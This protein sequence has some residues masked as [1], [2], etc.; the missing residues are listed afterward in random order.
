M[1]KIHFLLLDGDV[2]DTSMGLGDDAAQ[3]VVSFFV[4]LFKLAE[5]K[6]IPIVM[7]R[8][9]LSHDRNHLRTIAALHEKYGFKTKLYYVEKLSIGLI[10]EYDL[11]I[12]Y[13]PDNLPYKESDEAIDVLKEQMHTAGWDYVD[14]AFVHGY[15]RHVLPEGIP[16]EPPCTFRVEQFSFVKRYVATGHVHTPSQRDNQFYNGS[17]DRLGHG[18]EEPKGFMYVIDDGTNAEIHFIENE[19]ATP[20]ITYDLSHLSDD[21]ATTTYGKKIAELDH[22][23]TYHIRVIHGSVEVRQALGRFTAKAYPTVKYSHK[24]L[25]KAHTDGRETLASAAALASLTPPSEEQL[26]DMIAGYLEA[27]GTPLQRD[28]IVHHLGRTG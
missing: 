12:A 26:P 20:F 21:D 19:D 27:K 11:R 4:E 13:V 15:F 18:E 17:F 14:Y 10:E 9:T 7:L 25:K 28:R 1:D 16:R 24:G 3:V 2:T 23:K 8:G 22:R 6:G 5:D